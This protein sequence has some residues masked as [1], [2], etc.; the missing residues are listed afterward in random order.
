MGELCRLCGRDRP[1]LSSHIL[2]A[3]VFKWKRVSAGGS[4]LRNT[5]QPNLRVQD[6]LKKSFLCDECEALFSRDEG[7]FANKIFYPYVE[8]P[9]AQLAY[10]PSLLRFCTSVSWRVLRLALETENFEPWCDPEAVE[11]CRQAE[12]TWRAFLLGERE[13]PSD[14][15]QQL[16]PFDIIES[17]SGGESP[18]INRYLTRTIQ[19]DLCTNSTQ[20]FTFAKLGPIAIFG[21]IRQ[22]STPWKGTRIQANQ[23]TVGG[24]R[25]YVLPGALWP[26]LNAKARESAAAMA[27]I[28][29][30]QREVIDQNLRKNADAF[31]GSAAFRAMQADIEKFGNEAFDKFDETEAP[32]DGKEM[33]LERRRARS[34]A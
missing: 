4:P 15:R 24:R 13:H 11:L 21:T 9:A 32:G 26:Y 18:N 33:P 27:G 23:G 31:V 5:K 17:S 16:L 7:E 34:S 20:T 19:M 12:V 10:G 25:Q 28:S 30:K 14:F 3:F 22:R 6:G 2:P 8:N 1:L 29:K